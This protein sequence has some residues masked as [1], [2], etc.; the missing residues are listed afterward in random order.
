MACFLKKDITT[1]TQ[2]TTLNMILRM[3]KWASL[4][5][6]TFCFLKATDIY[7]GSTYL[8]RIWEDTIESMYSS[9]S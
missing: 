7:S 4:N 1:D 3:I 6:H 5:L 2:S 8:P 9:I